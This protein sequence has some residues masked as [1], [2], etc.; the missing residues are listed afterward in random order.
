MY[1]AEPRV[2]SRGA[3]S[4]DLFNAEHVAIAENTRIKL[5][6]P[7]LENPKEPEPSQPIQ[8]SNSEATSKTRK[9]LSNVQRFASTSDGHPSNAGSASE[10]A[11][12]SRPRAGSQ[13]RSQPA[14]VDSVG[15][16]G[17]QRRPI[18]KAVAWH[19]SDAGGLVNAPP[20]NSSSRK[21]TRPGTTIQKRPPSMRSR[22]S[23]EEGAA[24][25][26]NEL[27]LR[28]KSP[29]ANSSLLEQQTP[30]QPC[31]LR[32]VPSK[33]L[34]LGVSDVPMRK[35]PLPRSQPSGF[36]GLHSVQ[37]VPPAPGLGHIGSSQQPPSPNPALSPWAPTAGDG[38]PQRPASVQQPS[39]PRNYPA[40]PGSSHVP[41]R[42][43][44][45]PPE[46]TALISRESKRMAA[47]QQGAAG[48]KAGRALQWKP[49][50]IQSGD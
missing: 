2:N 12:N 49:P 27:Y 47:V 33:T 21:D 43:S 9:I 39:Q 23:M 34:E 22:F 48:G 7:G 36:A 37:Q 50:W 35:P 38:L 1:N 45:L 29:G 44:T 11:S 16:K 5:F 4:S 13:G 31:V 3:I 41:S 17:V 20:A 26:R 42:P 24:A 46:I 28:S 6:L 19:S 40:P 18:P 14:A 30:E 10:Q 25:R 8:K 32:A 15:S